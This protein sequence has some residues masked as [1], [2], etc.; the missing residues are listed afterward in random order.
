MPLS[1]LEGADVVLAA[2]VVL[3]MLLAG[4]GVAV[5]SPQAVK[6]ITNKANSTIKPNLFL[7]METI[8][9]L[10]SIS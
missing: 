1:L 5:L 7:N 2:T 9:L 10:F 3:A 6:A 4:A 8:F